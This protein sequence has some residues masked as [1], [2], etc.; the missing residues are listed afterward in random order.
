MENIASLKHRIVKKK[1]TSPTPSESH[2]KE[3]DGPWECYIG[4]NFF[5]WEAERVVVVT[6]GVDIL[7]MTTRAK[8]ELILI[9]AKEG[10][11]KEYIKA[12]AEEGLVAL[13]VIESENENQSKGKVVIIQH[14]PLRERKVLV[15][16]RRIKKIAKENVALDHTDTDKGV[17]DVEVVT[18][19]IQNLEL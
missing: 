6:I 19:E 4:D 9:I 8:T 1:Q 3:E 5:G 7:E 12:A 16:K 15:A 13:E 14:K 18:G 17:I 11:V 2:G 10:S